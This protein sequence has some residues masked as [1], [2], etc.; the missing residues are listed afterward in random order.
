[1]LKLLWALLIVNLRTPGLISRGTHILLKIAQLFLPCDIPG[2]TSELPCRT[3][4]THFWLQFRS[5][6]TKNKVHIF[7]LLQSDMVI[8]IA[9]HFS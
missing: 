7:H 9:N 4:A 8:G 2:T 3:A 1:M 6:E 5:S